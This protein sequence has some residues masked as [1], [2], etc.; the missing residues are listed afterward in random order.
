MTESKGGRM[1]NRDSKLSA[2]N[3]ERIVDCPFSTAMEVSETLFP[4]LESSGISI[5]I[6]KTGV[7]IPQAWKCRITV[8]FSRQI[9]ADEPGRAHDQLVFH[10]TTLSPLLPK[11]NGVLSFRIHTE[12][13]KVL[14][15]G[16]YTPPLGF[17]GQLFDRIIGRH[18]AIATMTEIFDQLQNLLEENHR[19]LQAQ[20]A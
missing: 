14:F 8:R 13:T 15:T 19:A 12:R 1:E 5:P 6:H 3:L 11:L 18:I 10:W 16:T 2:F 4:A 17:V 9:D 20:D 7:P